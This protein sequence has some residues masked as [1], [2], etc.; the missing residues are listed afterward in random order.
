MP[1]VPTYDNFQTNIA[2]APST[3]FRADT[4]VDLSSR[5]IRE[6]GE[7]LMRGGEAVARATIDATREANQV[8]LN[9]ALNKA[10]ES[11]LR[12][13]YSKDAGF[14]HLRGDAAL[15]RPDGKPLEVTAVDD[16]RSDLDAIERSLG[17][18]AQRLAF[19][20]QA[21]AMV[22]QF[23]GRVQSHV[24]QQFADYSVGVQ[25]GTQ[26]VAQE[27]MGLAW[28][29][30]KALEE[31]RFAIR[32]AVAEEGRIR[33]WSGMQVEAATT[34]QLSRGHAA[35]VMS[36]V[37]SG[38]VQYASEYLKQWGTEMDA[39]TRI[40]L[41]EQVRQVGDV[42]RG[43]AVAD[44]VWAAKG[45]KDVND[46]V[47]LFDMESAVRAQ[48]KDDPT[49]MK[50]G[51]DAVRQRAQAWNAQ[52]TETNA[53][54]V[55]SV[56]G[57]IDG[58]TS[59]AKVRQSA[60]WLALPETKQHEIVKAL[61]SE[62]LAREQRGYYREGMELA[63]LQRAE[64]L[65]LM[66]NGAAYLAYS[67]PESLSKMSRVEIQALRPILGLEATE[68]LLNRKDAI[69]KPNGKIEARMDTEDFNQVAG[70][71][72][73]DPFKKDAT[74][75]DKARVGTLKF[76]IEQLINA[77]QVAKKG[78]LT[79][80]EKMAL[81]REEMA[82][83]V[84]VDPGFFS[85]NKEVPVIALDPKEARKVVVPQA[86]REQ[87]TKALELK[88]RQN[89]NN[90]LFAPTED[91]VRRLYLRNRSKAGDLIQFPDNGK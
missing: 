72:G 4:P 91:N 11:E 28:G 77:A 66:K 76:R 40:K 78:A 37:T 7:G 48:F 60:A 52:Q 46:S 26:K 55:N 34:E 25:Q 71:M 14:V 79:R 41:Q 73:L 27:Q 35:A 68:H 17:N 32:S 49:A 24:A 64:K 51:I 43:D 86:D 10:K 44:A 65:A 6:Q 61:E 8:R 70:E 33:G 2:S 82:R 42:Q 16:Y 87:I 31:S 30:P 62:A 75:E 56:F 18:D 38:R 63:R 69:E 90:P 1:T 67:D 39:G 85:R 15:T 53:A 47:N 13:T 36:A 84:T 23:R 59:L 29:D 21:G 19:R 22:E 57:L 50:A 58:G 9:D 5:A 45:P 89:P 20:Q 81:V 88:Y 3:R 80:D 74:A 12:R 54:N 83:T